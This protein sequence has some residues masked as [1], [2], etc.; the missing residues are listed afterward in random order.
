[1]TH[2]EKIAQ[3]ETLVPTIRSKLLDADGIRHGFFTRHGGVSGGLYASLNGGIGSRDLPEAIEENRRRMA[4][5]LGIAP[6]RLFVPYQIHS[7]EAAII[8]NPDAERPCCDGLA[9]K[10]QNL[11]LGATGADCGMILFAD[12]E[13]R[14]IGSAH[15]GWKGAL[16]GV[17]EATVQAM[18][19]L[20]ARPARI[21]AALGP[22]IGP[23]SYE[24]G[25]EFVERFLRIEKAHADFFAGAARQ[26]HFLFDL[27]G[28]IGRRMERAGI[29][30]FEN[31][32]LDT[33]A[34]EDRFFSFRRSVHRREGDYGRQIAAITLIS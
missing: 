30:D 16:H 9:T 22:T 26:N 33:Y 17:I 20:G 29:G 4:D 11:G 1:M 15:A 8:D 19:V 27:P 34:D 3:S 25:A 23:K 10:I 21:K 5:A 2:M 14:V 24:V 18:K 32:Y 12:V 13:A 7:A 6:D 31:L 28:F